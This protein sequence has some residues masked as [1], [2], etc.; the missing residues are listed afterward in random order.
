MQYFLQ[1]VDSYDILN[2]Q[3]NIMQKGDKRGMNIMKKS[4][5]RIDFNDYYITNECNRV[6][7]YAQRNGHIK[8]VNDTFNQIQNIQNEYLGKM[9]KFIDD[10]FER[11]NN[12]Y[13]RLEKIHFCKIMCRFAVIVTF[14]LFIFQGKLPHNLF[15]DLVFLLAIVVFLGGIFMWLITKVIE[16]VFR[17]RYITYVKNIETQINNI[18]GIYYNALNGIYNN[19]DSLYLNSLEPALRETVLMRRDQE[20]QHKERLKMMQT[21]IENQQRIEQEQ[22]LARERQE[23]LLEIERERERRYKGY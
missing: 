20:R 10:E 5:A 23:E 11:E 12:L 1:Q 2:N 21:Q 8:G 14:I 4:F 15:M 13:S 7:E 6:I 18:N 9:K 19:I 17:N 3:N 22:K 16:M